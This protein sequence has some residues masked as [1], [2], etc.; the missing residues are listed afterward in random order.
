MFQ[1]GVEDFALF[2]YFA[3]EL[4]IQSVVCAFQFPSFAFNQFLVFVMFQF[5]NDG[6]RLFVD[7]QDSEQGGR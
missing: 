3:C 6:L 2:I 5:S 1:D 7:S 4:V